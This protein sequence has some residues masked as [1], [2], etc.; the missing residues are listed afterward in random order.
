MVNE[1]FFF[2][3]A[4]GKVGSFKFFASSGD[5]KERKW[6]FWDFSN[7]NKFKRHIGYSFV[8]NTDKKILAALVLRLKPELFL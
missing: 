7:L 4:Y 2:V 1:I 5:L 3:Y 8:V 6:A